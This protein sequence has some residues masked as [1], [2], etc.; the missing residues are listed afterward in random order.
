MSN[1]RGK[2]VNVYIGGERVTRIKNKY[3]VNEP[4]S[5]LSSVLDILE[6]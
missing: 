2:D 5:S 6:G 1:C 3:T 4:V